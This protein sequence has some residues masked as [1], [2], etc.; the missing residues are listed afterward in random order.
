[1]KER[2]IV[3]QAE[4]LAWL[5]ANHPDLFDVAEIERAWVWLTGDSLKPCRKGCD[6]DA[7]KVKAAKRRSIGDYGFIWCKGGHPMPSG[8][9]GTWSHACDHPIRFKRKGDGKD[10]S[11]QPQQQPST[12]TDVWAEAEALINS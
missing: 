6:C 12:T 1:V 11:P 2:N 10:R 4:C 7:C 9:T 8:S 3:S 5:K